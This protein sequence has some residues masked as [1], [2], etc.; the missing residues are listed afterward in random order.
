MLCSPKATA[1]I[2]IW[3][4]CLLCL[5]CSC[6]LCD[7]LQLGPGVWTYIKKWILTKQEEWSHETK[8]WIY[9]LS[10]RKDG[11]IVFVR[12]A[13]QTGSAGSE[14]QDYSAKTKSKHGR[15]ECF[16]KEPSRHFSNCPTFKLLSPSV[17]LYVP[18][19]THFVSR[20]GSSGLWDGQSSAGWEVCKEMDKESQPPSFRRTLQSKHEIKPELICW[21]TSELCY[22]QRKKYLH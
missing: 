3:E 19:L 22:L 9:L 8:L 5:T 13:D 7:R 15:R 2:Q 14:L 21:L 6:F 18:I 11:S 20:A 1:I 4:V 10:A 17:S 12:E 16:S